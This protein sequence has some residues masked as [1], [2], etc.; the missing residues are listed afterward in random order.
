MA[1]Q[2][3]EQNRIGIR[4]FIR[5]WGWTLCFLLWGCSLVPDFQQP[6]LAL[7]ATWTGASG[8]QPNPSP[9][10]STWWNEFASPEL[11]KLVNSGL[12]GN[13]NLQATVARIDE[14]RG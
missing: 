1:N 8:T 13:F 5:R 12:S 7:P 10:P 11:T 6:T 3:A 2:P 9:V 4:T 14:A